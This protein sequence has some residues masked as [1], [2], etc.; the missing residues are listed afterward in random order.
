MRRDEAYLLDVLIAAQKVLKFVSGLTEAEFRK[1][2]LVQSAVMGQLEIIGEACR[3][4]S[5][6][7]QDA[8]PEIPWAAIVGM[9]NKL[10]HEYFRIDV[11]ILWEVVQRDIPEL[12]TLVEPLVPPD[13]GQ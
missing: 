10:I 7:I 5:P 6:A 4:V 12:V 9:R 13:V 1:S 3:R 8:H 11:S 2:D